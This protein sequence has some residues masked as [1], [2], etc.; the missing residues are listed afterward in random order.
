MKSLK[1]LRGGDKF[2]TGNCFLSHYRFGSLPCQPY[3]NSNV[4]NAF[5]VFKKINYLCKQNNSNLGVNIR[6]LIVLYYS[7]LTGKLWTSLNMITWLSKWGGETIVYVRDTMD[8][9]LFKMKQFDLRP[10]NF[11]SDINAY[12]LYLYYK[13]FLV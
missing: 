8:K 12:S 6:A 2:E 9:R 5:F 11:L 13:R 4:S 7:S 1:I 3:K 10:H